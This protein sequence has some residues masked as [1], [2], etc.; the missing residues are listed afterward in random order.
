VMWWCDVF[1]FRKRYFGKDSKNWM[2]LMLRN[3]WRTHITHYIHIISRIYRSSARVSAS[4]T[5]PPITIFYFL[6]CYMNMN[7]LSYHQVKPYIP[8]RLA[9]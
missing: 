9:S 1:H 6:W 2:T 5:R 3:F 4:S 8:Q 7:M